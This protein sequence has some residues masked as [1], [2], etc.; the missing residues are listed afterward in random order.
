MIN[1]INYID[2]KVYTSSILKLIGTKTTNKLLNHPKHIKPRMTLSHYLDHQCIM[3]G[4]QIQASAVENS[5]DET[6]WQQEQ[7]PLLETARKSLRS[8]SK[9]RCCI[10]SKAGLLILCWNL[11]LNTFFVR[12]VEKYLVYNLSDDLPFDRIYAPI[13]FS[14]RAIF[15]LFY[16]LAGCLADIKCGRYKMVIY[17][18][19]VSV[20]V[21][22][23]LSV[24]FASLSYTARDIDSSILFICLIALICVLIITI[25]SS[26]GAYNVNVIQ[27]GMDQLHDS[28]VED[29]ELFIHWFVFTTCVGSV[30]FIASFYISITNL[31]AGTLITTI[32]ALGISLC[33]GA[34]KRHWFL[35]DSGSR[36]PYK[37]VYKVI[38][39]AAQH[40]SPIR[41]SAFTYCE[42]ELPSRMDLAKEKY[43]GPFTTEQ[44]EDVKAFLG[45]L[46]VLLTLGP[47]FTIDIGINQLLPAVSLHLN[48]NNISIPDQLYNIFQSN[49]LSDIMIATLIPIYI[50]VLRPFIRR[51]IPRMLKRM[52]LGMI[53]LLSSGLSTLLIDTIGHLHHP[54]TTFCFLSTDY[55]RYTY[56]NEMIDSLNISVLFLL[57]PYVLNALGYTLFYIATFEFI[58]AQSPHAMKGLLIGT[59]FAIKGVFQ[60]IGATAILIPFIS[61]DLETSFPSCGFVYYVINTLVILI[62]LVAYSCV[63]RRYQ[64]RQRDEPDNIYRYA[65]EYYD[66]DQDQRE[67]TYDYSN[68]CDNLNVHTVD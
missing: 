62:G 41:R 49:D 28:P 19:W 1:I 21:E 66:R 32:I 11:L 2:E 26:F 7:A 34:C 5:G 45:I 65:E 33:I 50:C 36:N 48:H 46:Q 61:W 3:S 42:D 55:S 58:C 43:G 35:I 51:Y 39:F 68:D 59:F 67:S 24:A 25:C 37:L 8:K 4:N 64:Y 22:I 14:I 40:E 56:H 31:F 63:S 10:H 23:F 12:S 57:F 38:K 6:E 27:F 18:L 52:G 20:L 17:S 47:V 29:S 44:V 30:V 60:L 15:Y 53:L 16:P 9:R 13:L 54:N